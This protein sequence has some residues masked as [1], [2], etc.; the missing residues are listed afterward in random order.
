[1]G[2]WLVLRVIV[3]IVYSDLLQVSRW[4]PRQQLTSSLALLDSTLSS[5]A[6]IFFLPY[7]FGNV[8]L[9]TAEKAGDIIPFTATKLEENQKNKLKNAW[10][11]SMVKSWEV[12]FT[13]MH[14]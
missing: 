13:G 12:V 5:H 11:I 9:A 4:T 14:H 10:N 8:M 7:A 1:M 2:V 6:A 3:H